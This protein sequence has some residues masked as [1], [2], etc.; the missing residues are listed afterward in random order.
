[1]RGVISLVFALSPVESLRLFPKLAELT[2]KDVRP[3]Y[4]QFKRNLEVQEM[5]MRA[6]EK[7][8]N[9]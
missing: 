4:A 5:K 1:M 8:L 2:G 6:V 3:C 7:L 9:E